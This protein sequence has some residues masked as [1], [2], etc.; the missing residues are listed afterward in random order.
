MR[1]VSYDPAGRPEVSSLVLLAA[2]CLGTDPVSLAEQVG[3]GGAA[4]LKRTVTEAVNERL[5]PVHARRA[6][7]AANPGYVRQVL[8]DGAECA[9]GRHGDAGRGEGRDGDAVL[10]SAAPE[11]GRG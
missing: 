9:G 4:L 1:A 8:R 6:E 5:R 11:V 7:L 2:L 10:T 3:G